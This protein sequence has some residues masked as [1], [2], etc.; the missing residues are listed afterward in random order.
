MKIHPV[1]TEFFLA[2]GQ[3]DMRKLIV[4]FAI[5]GN[6]LKIAHHISELME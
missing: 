5:L 1:R 3:T 2:D 6:R 4:A